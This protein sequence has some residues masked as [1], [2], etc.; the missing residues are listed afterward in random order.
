LSFIADLR[1]GARIV[2]PVPD[3]RDI[4]EPMRQQCRRDAWAILSRQRPFLAPDGARRERNFR[5][6]HGHDLWRNA[7]CVAGRAGT[8]AVDQVAPGGASPTAV[9]AVALAFYTDA[10]CIAMALLAVMLTA[11]RPLQK[12]PSLSARVRTIER[13][14]SVRLWRCPL[15]TR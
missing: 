3:N 6:A 8:A 10:G 11:E 13:A 15:V 7:A 2:A 14:W 12:G 9:Q 1:V 4:G 5:P